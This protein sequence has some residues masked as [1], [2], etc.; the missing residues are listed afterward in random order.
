MVKP[1]GSTFASTSCADA[2]L[3][4]SI[5]VVVGSILTAVEGTG[6]VLVTDILNPIVVWFDEI[7]NI[8]TD[9]AVLPAALIWLGPVVTIVSG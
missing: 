3:V 7:S 9:V 8:C 5:V 2:T 6:S 4:E 1:F